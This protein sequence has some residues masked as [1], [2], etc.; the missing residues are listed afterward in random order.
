[1]KLESS[2]LNAES[3]LLTAIL[4]LSKF[5]KAFFPILLIAYIFP[6]SFFL[7]NHNIR[8]LKKKQN[9]KRLPINTSQ[10]PPSAKI[11]KTSKSFWQTCPFRWLILVSTE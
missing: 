3:S 10:L 8:T 1:M 5:D 11:V 2:F 7:A 6:V 9:F 4:V